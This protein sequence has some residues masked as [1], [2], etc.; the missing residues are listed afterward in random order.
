MSYN[1][2]II[3]K[4]ERNADSASDTGLMRTLKDFEG[5]LTNDLDLHPYKIVLTEELHQLDH[6]ECRLFS[7]CTTT[8]EEPKR[9]FMHC[10]VKEDWQPSSR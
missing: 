6:F 7:N 2:H 4:C 5:S 10:W 9:T 8:F 3:E 1:L